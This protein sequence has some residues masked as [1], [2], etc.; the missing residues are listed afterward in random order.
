[1]SC[2]ATKLVKQ[3]WKANDKANVDIFMPTN[4]NMSRPFMERYA[5]VFRLS[6]N[7]GLHCYSIVILLILL[8]ACTFCAKFQNLSDLKLSTILLVD[9]DVSVSGLTSMHGRNSLVDL[10]HVE[11][12]DPSSDVL[13][14]GEL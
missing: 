6:P 2:Y 4:A 13:A 5:A 10:V 9:Q 7:D 11:L 3:V 14:L 1:M 8:V 12:L